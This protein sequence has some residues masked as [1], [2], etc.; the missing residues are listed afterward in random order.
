LKEFAKRRKVRASEGNKVKA[1]ENTEAKMEMAGTTRNSIFARLER[2]GAMKGMMTKAMLMLAGLAL[3]C[4][5]PATTHAQAEVSPDIYAIDNSVPI[6]QPQV[7]LAANTQQATEFQGNISLPY[8]VQCSGKK[9]AAGQYTV[10]VKTEGAKKTV[11]L[12]KDG[13]DVKLAVRQI[14]PASKADRSALLVQSAGQTRML[15]AVYVASMNAI[16]YLD[17]DWKLSLLDRMQA[18]ERLPIS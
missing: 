17:H 12:H 6:P 14:A 10:A 16:L 2:E 7:T 1:K 18:A 4:F 5:W 9:L 13:N 8:Q 3:V 11:V 15:E